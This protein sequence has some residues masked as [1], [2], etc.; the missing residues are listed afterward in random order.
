MTGVWLCTAGASKAQQ[1]AHY[2]PQG[3][4]SFMGLGLRGRALACATRAGQPLLVRGGGTRAAGRRR[5]CAVQAKRS[6]S[7]A[8]RS[9][10]LPSSLEAAVPTDQRPVNELAQ[11]K[12]D[13]F[14]LSWVS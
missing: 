13:P 10:G 5:A 12:D 2:A 4:Q 1:T 8:Q 11:L 3:S 14:L 9:Q 7:E 6:G